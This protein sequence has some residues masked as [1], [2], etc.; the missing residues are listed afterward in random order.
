MSI[1]KNYELYC[2]QGGNLNENDYS[3][4]LH[5]ASSKI[6]HLVSKDPNNLSSDI[7][8]RIF[9]HLKNDIATSVALSRTSKGLNIRSKKAWFIGKSREIILKYI[10]KN[11]SYLDYVKD[12]GWQDI[13]ILSAK[14]AGIAITIASGI[15]AGI[16]AANI[17]P[18][19]PTKTEKR[20]D[21]WG[22]EYEVTYIDHPEADKARA[23][24]CAA[25]ATGSMTLLSFSH[26]MYKM[27][28]NIDLDLFFSATEKDVL[29]SV[30]T[31][32]GYKII[33]PDFHK[34]RIAKM[35]AQLTSNPPHWRQNP[36]LN[37]MICPISGSFMLFPVKDK[38]GH[39]FDF[40]SLRAYQLNPNTQ[41]PCECPI[42]S[43]KPNVGLTDLQFDKARFDA[44]QA[45]I[46][47]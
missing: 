18:D 38:C 29:G 12:G 2:S 20:I 19:A 34:W 27:L 42:S 15:E 16:H 43:K 5:Q 22:N 14:L 9:D 25:I 46:H 13:V 32:F 28:Q 41:H 4:Y 45:S 11:T 30:S 3:T 26:D 44:I 10:Q 37:N 40:R 36:L 7:G 33:S 23:W 47:S 39:Y 31:N 6:G 24:T 17:P 1:Q 21:E 8:K 35:R